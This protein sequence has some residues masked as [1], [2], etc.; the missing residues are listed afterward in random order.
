MASSS[1]SVTPRPAVERLDGMLATSPG[2]RRRGQGFEACVVGRALRG[3][4][5]RL[6]E[7]T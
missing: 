5:R 6:D 4:R 1:S 3:A 2:G 7:A